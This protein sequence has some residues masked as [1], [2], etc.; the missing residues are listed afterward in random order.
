MRSKKSRIKARKNMKIVFSCLSLLIIFLILLTVLC[1]LKIFDNDK[2]LFE[3]RIDNVLL[4]KKKDTEEIKTVGWISIQGTNIDYPV[5]YAP[6]YDFSYKTD[7]FTWTEVD[8]NKLNNMI[9]VSGHNIL[10]QS[11]NPK[12]T[13]KNH[14]RFEQLMGFT[15]Y[16]FIKENQYIQYT[17]NGKDYIY[18]IFSVYYDETEELALYNNKFYSKKEITKFIEDAKKKNIYDIDVEVNNEDFLLSLVTCTKMFGDSK[19]NF[20]V[21]AR[22]LRDDEATILSKVLKS[23]KYKEVEKKMKGGEVYEEA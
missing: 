1:F 13:S 3:S 17:F 21:A 4:E 18:K 11:A 15:Y 12:I 14:R 16:D 19:E 6:G 8:Y 7:D 2:S 20:V 23:S 5:V 9:Y 10:N 22:L